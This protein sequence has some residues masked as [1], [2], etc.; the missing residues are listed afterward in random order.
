MSEIG[1][2]EQEKAGY[3]KI[4]LDYAL[5]II[6]SGQIEPEYLLNVADRIYEYIKV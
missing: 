6:G 2:S 5:E 1:L 4:S 3:R